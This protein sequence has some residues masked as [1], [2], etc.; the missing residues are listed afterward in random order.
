MSIL[1]SLGRITYWLAWPAYQVY[2]RLN[3]RTR[4]LLV[5][6]DEVLVAR[7]WISDG[8]WSLPGGG[9]HKHE[10]PLDGVLREAKEETGL[11]LRPQDLRYSGKGEYRKAGLHFTYHIFIARVQKPA[12]LKRQR[13]EVAELRWLPMSDLTPHNASPDALYCLQLARERGLLLQ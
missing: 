8:T 10:K 9:L 7:Q 3:E 6:Q 4:L 12:E 11:E 2:Y 5:C 1:Q 13:H